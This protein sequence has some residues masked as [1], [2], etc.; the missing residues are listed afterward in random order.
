MLRSGVGGDLKVIIFIIFTCV[1]SS[2]SGQLSDLEVERMGFTGVFGRKLVLSRGGEDCG[3]WSRTP[4]LSE[5]EAW[6]RG[7]V[8]LRSTVNSEKIIA[9]LLGQIAV[10][11][12]MC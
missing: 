2:Y 3:D 7:P 1:G 4:G 9:F 8:L 5:R 10:L 6:G 12:N 11:G